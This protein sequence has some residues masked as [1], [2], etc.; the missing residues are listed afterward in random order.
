MDGKSVSRNISETIKSGD[1]VFIIEINSD[2]SDDEEN[3][4]ESAYTGNYCNE[5][6]SL[7]QCSEQLSSEKEKNQSIILPQVNKD[8]KV[9]SPLKIGRDDDGKV[10]YIGLDRSWS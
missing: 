5:I 9:S 2:Y 8:A 7:Q 4:T 6:D 1:E 3:S 10:N